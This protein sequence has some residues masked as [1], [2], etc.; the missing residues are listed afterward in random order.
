MFHISAPYATVRTNI[1]NTVKH[2]HDNGGSP[3]SSYRV[4]VTETV[5]GRS[6][7]V[8]YWQEGINNRPLFAIDITGAADA[9]TNV[10]FYKS[11]SY[12]VFSEFGP[13]VEG[14]ALGTGKCAGPFPPKPLTPPAVTVLPAGTQITPL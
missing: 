8:A 1:E 10:T 3:V 12:A 6:A 4:V 9:G 11:G 13:Y 5:P 7:N 14:W 2:C